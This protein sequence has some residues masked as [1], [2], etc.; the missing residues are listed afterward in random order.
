MPNGIESKPL[1]RLHRQIR[2]VNRQRKTFPITQA[3]QQKDP[4]IIELKT[5]RVI[6]ELIDSE[7]I[8]IANLK[9]GINDYVLKFDKVM[10]PNTLS[11]QRLNIF[12]NIEVI[13][14]L[15]DQQFLPKLMQCEFDPEEIAETF[16][17]FINESKF[18]NY[19]VYVLNRGASEK[20]CKENEYFFVQIQTD[21]LGVRSFLL[22][23]IQRLPRYKLLLSEMTKELAADIDNNKNAIAACCIAE[24]SIQRLLDIMNDHCD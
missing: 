15:H 2:H 6:Q 17:T 19:I 3:V 7:R 4:K 1:S 20:L 9:R 22:Q 23:P 5:T 13:H 12:G 8:Y 24:K 16:T 21:R 11:G 10:L 14:E 18:D